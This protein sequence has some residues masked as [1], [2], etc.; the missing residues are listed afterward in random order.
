MHEMHEGKRVQI[1]YQMD[2]AWN[3]LRNILEKRFEWEKK[4]W[5]ENLSSRQKAHKLSR[6]IEEAIENVSRRNPETSIDREA[7]ETLSRR[8]QEISMDREAVEMLSR[9]QRAQ[10]NSSIDRESIKDLLRKKKDKLNRKEFVEDLS[11]SCRAWRK[12]V[13]QG[14]KNTRR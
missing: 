8:N 13:L 7:V 10:E 9:R 5:V 3:G 2:L 1:T 12:G 4:V 6:W 11:R 14:G